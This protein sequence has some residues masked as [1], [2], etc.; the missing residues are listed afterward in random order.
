MISPLVLLLSL[1]AVTYAGES[2]SDPFLG[3]WQGAGLGGPG[4]SSRRGSYRINFPAGIR[5]QVQTVGGDRGRVADGVL[6]FEQDGWSGQAAGERMAER[7]RNRA[8]C[9]FELKKVIGLS[10][11]VG[12]KHRRRG[13]LVRRS[14]FDQWEVQSATNAR[15]EIAWER[16]EDFMR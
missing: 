7:D 4:D 3:D 2:A 8:A 11:T 1:T 10:P 13:R 9:G 16:C 12:A 6:R 5:R 15:A 14:S